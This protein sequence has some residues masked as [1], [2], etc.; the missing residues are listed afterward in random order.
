MNFIGRKREIAAVVKS[1]KQNRN[2]VLAGRYGVGRSCLVK[3]VSE[4]CS[5]FISS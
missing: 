3:H 2:V 5:E 1:L 4:L